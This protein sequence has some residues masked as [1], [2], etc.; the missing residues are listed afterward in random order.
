M[1]TR[2]A[3]SA[4]LL[5]LLVSPAIAAEFTISFEWGNFP[6]CTS[7][8]PNS[9]P[10]PKFVLLNVPEGTNFIEFIMT[11]LFVPSFNHGGGTVE[12]K[13]NNVIERGAFTYLSPCPPSGS[14]TYRWIAT[15]KEKTGI[16][17]G[18]LGKAQ[19]TRDF[20]EK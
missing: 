12:Y 5:S 11:D 9:V 16:F 4:I 8:R 7:G 18:S 10:N 14:H 6:L 20:P 13:G 1:F 19:A 3:L 15:A 17:S 2:F